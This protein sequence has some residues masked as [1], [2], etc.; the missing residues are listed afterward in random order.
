MRFVWNQGHL[1]PRFYSK[2]R[3][4]GAQ[5]WNGL[6]ESWFG[7][8]VP[9]C[10]YNFEV[11]TTIGEWLSHPKQNYSTENDFLLK[12]WKSPSQS[13][14]S[15]NK[16]PNKWSWL[17]MPEEIFYRFFFFS[18]LGVSYTVNY[19][20][21]SRENSQ[22]VFCKLT[23]H[24]CLYFSRQLIEYNIIWLYDKRYIHFI[25]YSHLPLEGVGV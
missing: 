14:I 4:L 8:T 5:L 1:Q 18:S 21:D 6:F 19:H 2:A 13:I 16:W 15:R 3:S 24:H 23:G 20:V 22:L 17:P 7:C 25:S 12:P 9:Q 11:L 10:R